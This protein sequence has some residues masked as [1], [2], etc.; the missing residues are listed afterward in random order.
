ME[1]LCFLSVSALC[2]MIFGTVTS[3]ALLCHLAMSVLFRLSYCDIMSALFHV[4][5]VSY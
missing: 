1:G 4:M 2:H 3:D 5:S